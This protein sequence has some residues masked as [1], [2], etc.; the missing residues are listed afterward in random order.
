[1]KTL[2]Y[3]RTELVL[4]Q[5][6]RELK[7]PHHGQGY[8][9]PEKERERERGGERDETLHCRHTESV[10]HQRERKNT[11]PQANVVFFFVCLFFSYGRDREPKRYTT[12]EQGFSYGREKEK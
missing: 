2:H 3:R 8:A 12:S 10:L 11:K 7:A 6:E 4:H 5:R 1:M 9:T